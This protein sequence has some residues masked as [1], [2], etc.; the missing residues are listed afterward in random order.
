MPERVWWK[1]NG[2]GDW[3]S[4][5]ILTRTAAIGRITQTAGKAMAKSMARFTTRLKGFSSGSEWSVKNFKLSSYKAPPSDEV[6]VL[7]VENC[8]S[9]TVFVN[10]FK[11]VIE[12]R[13]GF[14]R[15]QEHH[16]GD[17]LLL[18][19]GCHWAGV[20]RISGHGSGKSCSSVKIPTARKPYSRL[21]NSQSHTAAARL[22]LPI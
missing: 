2:P 19:N 14:R 8:Q 10:G 13:G 9:H 3:K 1:N 20:P 11:Q 5:T 16:L 12:T 22:G 15:L 4:W 21:A 18:Q 6:F 17:P 7:V